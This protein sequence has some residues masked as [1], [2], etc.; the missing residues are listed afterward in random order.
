[1]T[2]PAA[3]RDRPAADVVPEGPDGLA[4][5]LEAVLFAT[6][7]PLLMADLGRLLGTSEVPLETARLEAALRV[8]E[9]RLTGG[10]LVV[11]RIAGGLRLSTRPEFGELLKRL[12]NEQRNRGLSPAAL[13]ALA[14]VAYRQPIT[15]SELEAIRGVDST[16]ILL[17][18]AERHL[19][20]VC[21]RKAGERGRP[22]VY[23]TTDHFLEVFGLGSLSDL[24]PLEPSADFSALAPPRAPSAAATLPL[25]EGLV[26]ELAP[27]EVTPLT[28]PGDDEADPT[29]L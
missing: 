17:A 8:L 13:D 7:E 27:G 28:D 18:L 25:F 16:G 19:V 15:K 21:G 23:G 24:P 20:R 10:A 6:P 11:Q 3:S 1:M 2:A 22:Y 14:I 26:D 4:R 12:F 9:A 29:E 5:R